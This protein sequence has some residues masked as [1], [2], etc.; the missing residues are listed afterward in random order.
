MKTE[1]KVIPSTDEGSNEMT[2]ANQFQMHGNQRGGG[3]FGFQ[4]KKPNNQDKSGGSGGRRQ[5]GGKR[6]NGSG[7]QGQ[8]GQ[9][10]G[11]KQV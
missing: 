7:N 11:R 2:R 4:P 3:K 10:G 1:K 8:N 9:F 5:M 6:K